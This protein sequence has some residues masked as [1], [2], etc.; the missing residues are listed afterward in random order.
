MSMYRFCIDFRYL[1]SQT[2][3]FCYNI[4]DVH[5]SFSHRTHNALHHLAQYEQQIFFQMRMSPRS[6]KFTAFN[7]C[8]RKFKFSWL[9][10]GLLTSPNSFYLLMDHVWMD[11]QPEVLFVI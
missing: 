8:F 3:T 1:N 7:I 6:N 5:E 2:Q 9:P 10:S 4:P 11:C